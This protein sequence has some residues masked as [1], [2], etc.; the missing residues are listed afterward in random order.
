[1]AAWIPILKASLP[2]LT[3]I[4]A[5]TIPAFT[6]KPDSGKA[7]PVTSKQIAE[8][9]KAATHNAETIRVLAEKLQQTIEGVD[10]AAAELQKQNSR[11]KNA[12]ILSTTLAVIA[13]FLA[14]VGFSF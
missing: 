13:L 9:Q 1:M 3:Q 2:Y 8:L 14:V 6:A 7:D 10:Q 5:T 12:L 11:L 4:V